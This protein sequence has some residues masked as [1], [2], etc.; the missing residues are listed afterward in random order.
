MTPNRP[1]YIFPQFFRSFFFFRQSKM[2]LY[3]K[4]MYTHNKYFNQ[5][6]GTRCSYIFIK[7]VRKMMRETKSKNY[8]VKNCKPFFSSICLVCWLQWNIVN[9]I[10][11]ITIQL[12]IYTYTKYT[13]ILTF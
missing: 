3:Q 6:K 1:Y 9:D 8:Y 4:K 5:R 10:L 11:Y 12:Y 2:Y 7:F 13:S